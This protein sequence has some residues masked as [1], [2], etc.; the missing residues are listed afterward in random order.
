MSKKRSIQVIVQ[1]SHSSG[2]SR[3]NNLPLGGATLCP[4]L[5]PRPQE[6]SSLSVVTARTCDAP[7]ATSDTSKP[8]NVSTILA[9][10]G[11]V[12]MSQPAGREHQTDRRTDGQTDRRTDGQTDVSTILAWS[13]KVEMSQPAGRETPDGQT[14]RR[15]DGRTDRLTDGQTDRR[16][17]PRS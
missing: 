2:A 5:S 11:K 6:N 14:N 3:P 8:S 16:M 1:L 10:S 13:G 7:Q 12:E 4:P 15:T 9:W 17:T